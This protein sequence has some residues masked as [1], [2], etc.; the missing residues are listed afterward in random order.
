MQEYNKI[1]TVFERDVN[2]T[3]KLIKGQFRSKAVE[4]LANNQWLFTEKID[5]TNIRVHWDGHRVEFGGRTD[6]A[7]IPATLVTYLNDTFGG[8]A[9]EELFEQKFGENEVILFGE[10]YGSG[11][12]KG[13]LYRSDVSFIL[14]DVLVG[15]TYLERENVE[16][17]AKTFNID[18]VPIIGTGTIEEAVNIVLTKPTSTI[19]KAPMEGIV[20]RPIVEMKDRMGIVLSRRLRCV[21]LNV[22]K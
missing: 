11:I 16:D 3:K 20:A 18:V 10:G 19:G 9:N 22:S 12:Q 21:T 8:D 15:E 17:I 6:R 5:G 14:F 2:G 7:Q 4:Y 13:G 1:D